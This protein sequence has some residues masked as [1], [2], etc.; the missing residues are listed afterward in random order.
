VV[1]GLSREVAEAKVRVWEFEQ[2]MRRIERRLP[3]IKR[4]FLNGS[5]DE[6]EARTL[7]TD[8]ELLDLKINELI[9]EWK[10]ERTLGRVFISASQAIK[11]YKLRLQ[12][13]DQLYEKLLNLNYTPAE[14]TLIITQANREMADTQAIRHAKELQKQEQTVIKTAKAQ[15]AEME[16]RNR[17]VDQQRVKILAAKEKQIK[18]ALSPFSEKNLV[19]F[20]KAKQMTVNEIIRILRLKG[21]EANAIRVWVK[22]FLKTDVSKKESEG[23][24]EVSETQERQEETNPN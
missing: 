6:G 20:F 19:A 11:I 14:A 7:L 9:R 17:L 21:W 5:I 15:K 23:E 16:K 3:K 2:T 22:T 13:A 4:W 1:V 24:D 8:L 12:N 10:T 18:T